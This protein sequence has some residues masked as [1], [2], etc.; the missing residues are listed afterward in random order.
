MGAARL[1]TAGRWRDYLPKPEPPPGPVTPEVLRFREQ[2][3]RDTGEWRPE[4]GERPKAQ[5]A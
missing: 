1:L 4:W 3:F 2:H 5:A